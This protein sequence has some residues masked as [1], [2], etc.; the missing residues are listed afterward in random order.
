MSR[1]EVCEAVA[2][3]VN[4]REKRSPSVCPSTPSLTASCAALTSVI[5][6]LAGSGTLCH[7]RSSRQLA[8][9]CP[10]RFLHLHQ[11]TRMIPTPITS[12]LSAADFENV[13]EPAGEF[14]SVSC[15]PITRLTRIVHSED[16][17]ILLDALE[18]DAE[19]LKGSRV[20]LE[21]G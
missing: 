18:Q 2:R 16:T 5:S 17:F 14:A 4:E 11:S 1:Q 13:Y 8:T 7:P 12:H 19:L 10:S 6:S 21:I 15:P 9:S 20:C 3:S